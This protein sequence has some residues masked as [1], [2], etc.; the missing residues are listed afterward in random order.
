M[1]LGSTN[2]PA[3]AALIAELGRR[4]ASASFDEEPVSGLDSEAIDFGA[5]S[6]CFAERRPLRRRDLAVLGFVR[7]HRGRTVPT[8]GGLLLFGRDRL[9]T[10]P[11]AYIQA[12]R[13]AGTDRTELAD[14]AEL[15][16][17]PV[18][19][20][21][22]AVGFVER[23]TRLGMT[24]GRVRRRDLPAVPPTASNGERACSG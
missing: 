24:I 16:E 15:T 21:E 4:P 12:G 9:S 22:Q 3:D 8:V 5:A 10:F 20:L 14:R 13:F 19:A 1:R 7:A 6:Q 23:N 11:D 2:R 17:Y 18:L